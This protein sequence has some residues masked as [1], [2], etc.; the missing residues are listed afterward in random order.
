[1]RK[2]LWVGL[3][4]FF[5]GCAYIGIILPGVPTTF[6]VILAAWA[7]SKSSEKFNKWIHEHKLF[8]KYLTNWE[9]KKVYPTRG[10]YAMIGVMCLSLISMFFTLPLRIV[11]YAAFTFLLICIW[12]LRYPGSVEEYNKRIKEGK[13]IG[14]FK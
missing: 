4:L 9:T 1:M 6:F 3:G 13:K 12:A 14:W 10:R 8:G 5:V 11:G 2:A 7:F